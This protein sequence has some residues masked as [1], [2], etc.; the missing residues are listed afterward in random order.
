MGKTDTL[1][2][3]N[4]I[5]RTAGLAQINVLTQPQ[6]ERMKSSIDG[7]RYSLEYAILCSIDVDNEVGTLCL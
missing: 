7:V 5:A 1:Q 2:I 6:I 3:V 4:A